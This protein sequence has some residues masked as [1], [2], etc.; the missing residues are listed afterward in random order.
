MSEPLRTALSVI[1][2]ALQSE[3]QARAVLR[4]LRENGYAC[5]PREPTKEMLDEGWYYAHDED[6]LGTWRAMIDVGDK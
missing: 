4:L 3:A 5:V 1:S 6:A 2:E